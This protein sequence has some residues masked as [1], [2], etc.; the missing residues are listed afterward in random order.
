MILPQPTFIQG[1]VCSPFSQA[2]FPLPSTA[3]P[4][5][6]EPI[7]SRPSTATRLRASFTSAN[8]Q[9][10]APPGHLSP[11]D[12]SKENICILQSVMNLIGDVKEKVAVMVD[13]MIDTA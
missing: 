4:F 7:S 8:S 2:Q 12:N 6:T 5:Q 11:S 13:D 10:R 1:L 3:P 9:K